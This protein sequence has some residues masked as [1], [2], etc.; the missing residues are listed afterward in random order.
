MASGDRRFSTV[1]RVGVALTAAIILSATS[2]ARGDAIDDCVDAQMRELRLPGLALAVVREG[3]VAT[4]RTYGRAN[5]EL[6]VPVTEETVFEIGSVTKQFTSA[7]LLMLVEEGKVALDDSIAKHLPHVPGKWR[8]ITVRHL[9]NHSAGIQEYLSVAGLADQAHA[10]SSHDEMTRLLGQRLKLEFAPGETWAYSNPGYL[11][12]G[13]IIERASGKSYWEFLRERILTPLGMEATRSSDPR[14]VIPKR[15]AGYGWRGA[16]FENRDALHENAY[17]AGAIVSTI[18]DMARWAASWHRGELLSRRSWDEIWTP[19]KVKRGAVPPFS[20]GFGW[21]VDFEHGKRAVFHSGGTPGF[22]S[23]IRLYPD[24]D[25]AVIVLANHGDRIL[26]HLPME[27]AAI[28][29]PALTREQPASDPEPARSERLTTALRGMLSGKPDPKLFTPAMQLFL[30]TSSGG[31]LSEWIASHGELKS[32]V[33]SQTEPAGE[34]L[35][36]RYRALVGE[37]HLWFSFTV[38]RD[39]KIAQVYWW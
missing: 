25:L 12:L 5:L 35:T 26:D 14:A 10:A 19:L 29:S 15:A 33:Y 21:V 31:G 8:G 3:E 30:Q 34:N 28:V 6:D 27:I 23:A 16:Q 37:A 1:A 36:V 38:T 9:L 39:G 20:Y 4:I 18:R 11:L 13:N 17:A 2:P 24:E 7:A 32:L 22:S